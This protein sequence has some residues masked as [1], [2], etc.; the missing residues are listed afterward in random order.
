MPHPRKP[1]GLQPGPVD[2]VAEGA[3][4]V[5]G[6]ASTLP[7]AQCLVRSVWCGVSGA[8]V[9]CRLWPSNG[10]KMMP[11]RHFAQMTFFGTS[12]PLDATVAA[13]EVPL[14]LCMHT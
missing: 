1:Q 14:A 9:M 5:R 2:A 6:M 4:S 12:V 13:A 11:E 8:E 7:G 10:A 3:V